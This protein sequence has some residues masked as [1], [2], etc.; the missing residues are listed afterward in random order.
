MINRKKF[1]N[2]A[3]T[4]AETLV[5]IGIIGVVAALTLPNLN[6]STG[7][8]ER[9]T[10]VKKIY[11]NLVEAVD[12]AQVVYGPL[13]GWIT[14]DMS[15][16]NSTKMFAERITEFMKLSKVCGQVTKSGCFTNGKHRM[17]RGSESS[18]IEENELVYK[19]ITADGTSI[20][21]IYYIKEDGTI[22]S[23]TIVD[24]DGPNKG[25]NQT[26][27]DLFQFY[28]KDDSFLPAGGALVGNFNVFAKAVYQNNGVFDAAWII[29]FDNTDYLLLKDDKG[30]CENGNVV[31]EAN[32]SCK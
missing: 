30:N 17:Q 6:N 13:N 29:N 3:F 28:I 19:V 4:L 20:G 14:N 10:K 2:L 16:A 21:F 15:S 22:S 18:N 24:I 7:D 26:G 1:L 9:I 25:K 32:P 8:K 12:R 5:V 31:T 27:Y 11:S 23:D